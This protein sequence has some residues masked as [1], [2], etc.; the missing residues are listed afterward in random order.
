MSLYVIP[1]FAIYSVNMKLYVHYVMTFLIV[2]K[3][4]HDENENNL[5]CKILQTALGSFLT[6]CTHSISPDTKTCEEESVL[7][8]CSLKSVLTIPAVIVVIWKS[9]FRH[10]FT[11]FQISHPIRSPRHQEGESVLP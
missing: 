8:S 6:I 2:Q 3:G 9:C 1:S 10:S 4:Q 7:P 11:L 5:C